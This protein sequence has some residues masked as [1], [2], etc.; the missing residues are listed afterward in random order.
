M[1]HTFS[2]LQQCY[3]E[4]F[5]ARPNVVE[6]ISR[7]GD[8]SAVRFTAAI[9]LLIKKKKQYYGVVNCSKWSNSAFSLHSQICKGR[10]KQISL[11]CYIFSYICNNSIMYFIFRMLAVALMLSRVV[12]AADVSAWLAIGSD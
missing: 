6:S 8:I 9:V 11:Q 7:Y 4:H 3:N 1:N 5:I 2:D 12:C 10:R